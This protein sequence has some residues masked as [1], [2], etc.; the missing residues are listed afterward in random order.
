MIKIYNY[1]IR[2]C[3]CGN[4]YVPKKKEIAPLVA[5]AIVAGVASAASAGINAASQSSANYAN[6]NAAQLNYDAQLATNGANERIAQENR[7][8]NT[9]MW[10]KQNAYNDP[11]AQVQRFLRAG[12]NPQAALG[13]IS[14]GNVAS[15]IAQSD[16]PAQTAPQFN[17]HEQPVNYDFTGVGNAM[18]QALQLKQQMAASNSQ[19]NYTNAKAEYEWQSLHSRLQMA[20]N[21]AQ[22][23]TVEYQQAKRNLD[24]FEDTYGAQKRTIEANAIMSEKE[25]KKLSLDIVSKKL[26]NQILRIDLRWRDKMN[27][28]SYDSLVTGIKKVCSDIAVNNSTAAL[29]RAKQAVE[30]AR[31]KGMKIS[32][33]QAD[34]L[35][36]VIVDKAETELAQTE[37]DFFEGRFAGKY[38]PRSEKHVSHNKWMHGYQRKMRHDGR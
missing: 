38:L 27:S 19:I 37:A 2:D 35:V 16:I 7:N 20:V 18:L 6:K 8:Y 1:V 25:V 26:E 12:I 3:P 32:N 13:G 24:F 9:Q 22:K 29:N 4:P 17:Y 5:A 21:S 33:E 11:S 23:G 31:E 28:A 30:E 14:Q 34:Q 36:E 15:Q 10:E